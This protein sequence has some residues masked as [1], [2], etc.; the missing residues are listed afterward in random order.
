MTMTVLCPSTSSSTVKTVET[1]SRR[2]ATRLAGRRPDRVVHPD[3][4]DV[5]TALAATDL[6]IVGTRLAAGDA[7]PLVR[8]VLGRADLSRAV[9]FVVA[10]GP[11]PD[12]AGTAGRT[13][14]PVL[15]RTGAVCPAPVLHV[16]GRTEPDAVI[17]AYCRYWSPMVAMLLGSRH[18]G[19]RAAA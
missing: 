13:L 15:A 16:D 2:F 10:V 9:L 4:A 7:D 18:G 5:H 3:T 1:V 19:A 14:G 11:W 17:N 8:N 6:A 12:E